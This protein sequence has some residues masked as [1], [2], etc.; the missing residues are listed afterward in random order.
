MDSQ[1]QRMMSIYSSIRYVGALLVACV[2]CAACTAGQAETAAKA[3]EQD[4]FDPV[5]RVYQ[6]EADL[7]SIAGKDADNE[8]RAFLWVPPGCE[9]LRGFVFSGHNQLEEGILEDP[10]FRK[11]LAA[12][13]FGE[14]WMTRDIDPCGVFDPSCGAQASF[15]EAIAKLADVSGYE[16]LKYAPVVYLSHSA[17]AS[18]PW[19]FGAWN[20]E[21][22]LAMIS[23]HGD[24]PRSTF[25]CCNHHNPDWGG[26]D[27]DGIPGLICIGSEEFQEFRIEDSFRFMRQYP[28]SLIS[29]LINDGRGH[30]DFSDEDL[31]YL[32]R[33]ITKA[34]EARLPKEWD[35]T[36]PMPL[37]RLRRQDGWLADRWHRD[38][39]PAA[40]TNTWG[41]Y[42]GNR[43]SA[44]WYI[45]EEMAR[46]T[47][48]VYNRERNKK[49]QYL[50][51]M[52][53]GRILKPGEPM[54]F[55]TDGRD[56]D[57]RARVVFTDSTYSRLSD[58]HG[59]E[60]IRLK[61]Y[62]GEARIV[63]DTTFRLSFYRPGV[64]HDRV[65]VIGMFAFSESDMIYGHAVC[66]LSWR[67]PRALTEGTPQR[68]TFPQPEDVKAGTASLLLRATSD[69]G[70]PVRYY[71]RGGPAYVEGD[72]LRFTPIPPKAKY[73][74]KVTVVAWQY[75]SMVAPKVRTAEA[76]TRTLFIHPEK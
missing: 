9:R 40:L 14:V 15:D 74:V 67:M 73:P 57:V 28:E 7:D 26:R 5:Y 6:W 58:E 75:G 18:E 66:P 43:D 51:V 62:A 64:G 60:P 45:D 50:A 25:L 22:T 34:A 23:F 44:Y 71:V 24:S 48:S 52:Q 49:R 12:L 3:A 35:G 10:I 56:I 32:A 13:D 21:R 8:R 37:K 39:L 46:R 20:P 17:Q 36:S 61:R 11:A 59:I 63:N 65:G 4:A 53:D 2:C 38:A 55:S 29:L 27:I 69:A 68:V 42:G 19:N 16:E 54:A 1:E 31:K 72:T 33:F 41:G 30:S 76:V 70:L 47:E